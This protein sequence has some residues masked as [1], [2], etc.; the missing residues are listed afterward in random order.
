[1]SR[2]EDTTG[3]VDWYAVGRAAYG[4]GVNRYV[5]VEAMLRAEHA[6][7][8]RGWDSAAIEA[9]NAPVKGDYCDVCSADAD[10][11]H[12]PSCT[13]VADAPIERLREAA[14]FGLPA[15]AYTAA[16]C[17]LALEEGLSDEQRRVLFA[18]GWGDATPADARAECLEIIRRG[19]R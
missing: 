6:D 1:M 13:V 16:L 3:A 18:C 5:A 17:T 10:Q 14:L 15:D 4:E 12:D 2:A 19:G 11:Y 8:L 9:G 7:W